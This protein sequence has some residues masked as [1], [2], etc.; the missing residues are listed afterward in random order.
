MPGILVIFALHFRKF[1]F[2][3]W[4]NTNCSEIKNLFSSYRHELMTSSHL[5]TWWESGNGSPF[6]SSTSHFYDF[7]FISKNSPYL[8]YFVSYLKFLPSYRSTFIS[9]QK[10]NTQ[11]VI[12]ILTCVVCSLWLYLCVW[13]WTVKKAYV[14]EDT[15][16][17]YTWQKQ[18]GSRWRV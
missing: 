4:I 18:I 6:S 5:V 15:V 10:I 14:R 2:L 7:F 17:E 1:I 3:D 16:T 12:D 13:T 11:F 9:S 8:F